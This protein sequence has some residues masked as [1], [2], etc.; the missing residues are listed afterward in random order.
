MA[1]KAKPRPSAGKS[2]PAKTK[3]K[4]PQK[5]AA[6]SPAKSAPSA[7]RPIPAAGERTVPVGAS[8]KP[9]S[10]SNPLL[11]RLL[12]AT[13]VTAVTD[14]IG[15]FAEELSI[16]W[17]PVGDNDNNLAT[18]N[19]G[20][21]PAA[22]VIE[23]ITNAIDAV[24]EQQ[25]LERKQ[26]TH[27][28]SPR[29]A[30][31]E[32]F[33]IPGGRLVN[34]GELDK[35]ELQ[36]ITELVQVTFRDSER[37]DRP[38]VDIR[39]VGTG[40]LAEE[41][42]TSILGIKGN[43]KL[44]KLFLAGAFGQGGLSALAYSHYTT[45]VS[46]A[47]G[48][49]R[50]DVCP[51]ALTIV[52]FN[53]GNPR[54]DK[55]GLYEYMVDYTTGQP[56]T[57]E[58]EL[59]DFEP[60]T[61]V[62]HVSMDLSKYKSALTAPTGSPYWLAHNY[63]FDPIL[64]FRIAEERE[65][66]LKGEWR[67]VAGNHRLLSVG[68]NTEYQREARLTFRDG[69][70]TMTWWVLDAEG[71]AARN[72]IT[73]YAQISKPIIV[74]YNGQ[75]QGDL[76]NTVIKTELRLP[77]L[78]RYIIVHVDCDDLDPESRRQLFPTTRESIRDTAIGDD[79]R[80]LVVDT[81]GADTELTRLDRERKQ[82]YTRRVDSDSVEQIRRRLATR[83]R[84][85]VLAG[86]GGR[87]PRSLPPDSPSG[88]EA[89]PPIPV[90]NPPTLLEI[91]S[92]K[93][94]KVYAGRSFTLKFRTDADPGLFASPDTFIAVIN[95][96]SFGQYTGT[97]NVRNGYGV[98]HFKAAEDL[99]V[100]TEGQITLEVRPRRATSLRA[101]TTLEVVALPEAG[102]KGAGK[103]ATPNINPQW[104][105]PSDLIW[106]EEGW[107]NESV[108]KVVQ[109]ADGV[110][111]FVSSENRRLGLLIARAQRKDLGAV[112]SVKSFYLE[113]ISYYAMLSA[114]AQDRAVMQQHG[115]DAPQSDTEGELRRACETV[116]GIMDD[117]YEL[118]AERSTGAESDAE[119]VGAGIGSD[120]DDYPEPE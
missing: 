14:V 104:I 53:P 61:L 67:T 76:P 81:L 113:H 18:I 39:D 11:S 115:E 88:P 24:L 36:A 40:L 102:G 68:K 101:E 51:V 117:V 15:D 103:V 19:L 26:P 79:L 95:P 32:W 25:W 20:S 56:F 6:K 69:Y 82:R 83:I 116:C 87:S 54:I 22:G 80:R 114:L 112:E 65:N 92:P 120:D 9:S 3:A 44:R 10:P 86:G 74:T 8:T 105:G 107:T 71:E 28:N 45:I 97:T 30:V 13:K 90:E 17:K 47:R 38:T 43:R 34:M 49:T 66:P 106:K 31:E 33:G 62:R 4:S 73:Q 55:H 98:A 63:L 41:F 89:P 119:L 72:R 29:K 100:G 52:R 58:A 60:G 46:R 91:T 85:T 94:R 12:A 84:A 110:D 35:R 118:L 96:P 78:E 111:I 77:Y 57:F 2:K 50:K 48:K 21:D 93:P 64:P 23:R 7:L 5:S 16:A 37:S 108:A 99:G 59:S 75:K 109:E 42:S 70:V 1:R 27:L